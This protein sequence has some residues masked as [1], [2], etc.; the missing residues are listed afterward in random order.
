MFND[1]MPKPNSIRARL[2]EAGIHHFDVPIHNQSKEWLI[3]NFKGGASDYPVNISKLMRNIVW[4]LREEI[5]KKAK[6]PLHELIRTFWYMYIKP[7]L[8]RL[9]VLSS[10]IDQYA[11]LSSNIVSM[12][13]E[14]NIMKYKNIGFRDDNQAYRHV[15]GNANILLFSEKLGQQDFLS[16]MAE[17]YNVSIIALGGQ[18]SVLNIE[19]FV[20][21]L[22]EA[23][24]NLKRSFYLFSIVDYDPSGWIIRDALLDD[25]KFYGVSHTQV[26][27]LVTPDMLTPEEVKLARFRIPTSEEMRVKNKTWLTAVHKRNY[28]NQE[29]LEEEKAGKKILFGIESEAVSS[30]RMTLKLEQEMLP[31][32]GKSEDLLKIFELKRLD[33][34][35]KDLIIFKVT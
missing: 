18:P 24:I 2:R 28:Q 1:F 21:T 8:A 15:G 33:Q 27:D 29:F 12:V 19:Y 13:K 14:F 23:K 5:L 7:V 32:I 34:A 11:Q 20:D 4:Q 3:E 10:E 17:K 31:L 25:L 26:V 9:D 22:R 35:I 30:Q 16:D 6:P